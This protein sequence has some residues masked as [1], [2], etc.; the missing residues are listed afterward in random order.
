[1]IFSQDLAESERLDFLAAYAA[2]AEEEEEE[3]AQ[4][5]AG[6]AQEVG[7]SPAPP[8]APLPPPPSPYTPARRRRSSSP[9]AC[10]PAPLKRRSGQLILSPVEEGEDS[11]VK[12][13]RH[14]AEYP[15]H[16][17]LC[18]TDLG[19][20]DEGNCR[21]LLIFVREDLTS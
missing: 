19:S 9:P 3:E 21:Q 7:P 15:D 11:D 5:Q 4:A 8:A 1:M 17:F 12:R 10:P 13:T 20:Q 14:E 18:A 16:T 2:L 6:Q